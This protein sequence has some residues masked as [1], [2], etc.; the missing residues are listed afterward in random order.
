MAGPWEKYAPQ[1]QAGPWQKYAQAPAA[2][3]QQAVPPQAQDQSYQGAVLP[4]SRDAQGDVS[5]D[6]NAGLLGAIKRAVM[7]PGDAMAGQVDPL[8]QE[9]I[10]RAAEFA[11][12]FG[13]MSPAAGTG[14][15]IAAMAP[16]PVSQGMEAAAAANRLGVDLPRAVA[17]D[18]AAVQQGGKVLSNI[19]IGGTPLRTASKTAIDQIGDAATRV[20]QG[21]G[22]G[23]IANAGAAARQGITDFATKTLSGRVKDAYDNV[24][25]LVTQNVTTP[26][27]ETAKTAADISARRANAALGPSSSVNL[28]QKAVGQSDGLNYQG[29]KDLRTSIGEMLDKPNLMPA[30]MSEGEL[31]RIYGSLTTD[32]KSAVSRSGGD[33]AAAAFEQANQLAAKTAR[34]REALNK[35]LGKDSSDERIFDRITSMAGSNSRGDRVALMRVKGAVGS[36]TWND[37]ASG[38]ISKIGRDPDGNFS[39]DRFLT[40]YGKLSTDGKSALFGGKKDLASSLDDIATISRQFKQLNQYANPSGTGQTV[41]GAS[42][43]SGVFLEP[44]T[45]IGSLVGARAM[46]SILS[47]PVSAKALAAYSKAYQRQAVAPTAASTQTL[48]NTAR[49][50]AAVLGNEAGDKSVAAQIFPAISSVRQVPAEQGNENG[51]VPEAQNGG[52]SQQLRMLMPNEM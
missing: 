24:D 19:P 34:E 21:Y 23:N 42:Y 50:L 52:V 5:F 46:S 13:P 33:K 26:L 44:T 32:L 37:L 36:D 8:S 43:L 48:Q 27:S 4:I 7:L 14:K 38:V 22:T 18:S 3:P 1:S 10:G 16:K 47:K 28:V 35:V 39:P 6:S 12:T 45:V 9:G 2:Q 20:Q 40:S 15:A 51:N 49:V 30:D 25:K 31:K 11:G 17:S 29:I 41:A